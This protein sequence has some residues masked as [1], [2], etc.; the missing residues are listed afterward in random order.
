MGLHS[1]WS[2]AA[3]FSGLWHL[4]KPVDVPKSS[5]RLRYYYMK[6]PMSFLGYLV[7]RTVGPKRGL[8]YRTGGP[9]HPLGA[10]RWFHIQNGWDRP[11][12]VVCGTPLS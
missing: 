6:L 1:K 5:K 8:V 9:K 11:N 3:E 10:K 7:Y 12:S 2:G 4:T